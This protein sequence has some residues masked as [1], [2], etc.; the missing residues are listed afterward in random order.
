MRGQLRRVLQHVLILLNIL[1][2]HAD[3]LLR[4]LS[5]FRV[6]INKLIEL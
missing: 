3:L 6:L 2:Y 5:G 4:L 1:L